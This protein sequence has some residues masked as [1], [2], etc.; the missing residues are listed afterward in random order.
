MKANYLLLTAFSLGLAA[1]FAA[2]GSA[3]ADWIAYNEEKDLG[4][5][6]SNVTD[7]N[8]LGTSSG[9]LTKISDGASTGAT[10]ATS[11]TG[12]AGT[13]SATHQVLFADNGGPPAAGTDAYTTFVGMTDFGSVIELRQKDVGHSPSWPDDS[14]YTHSFSGLNPGMK[15]EFAGTAVRKK[16]T[17]GDTYTNRWTLAR[18]EGADSYVAAHTAIVGGLEEGVVTGGSLPASG[19][20][21]NEVAIWTGENGTATQGFV[22]RWTDI[23]P[24]ADG[25]FSVFCEQYTG[26]IP[27]SV[28]SGG[29][30][31]ATKGY[32][33]NVVRLQEVPE[34][35]TLLLLG[36]G[37]LALAT[38]R[39][40]RGGEQ[41][42][43]IA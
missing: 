43:P 14:S 17:G 6:H 9:L 20:A 4:G 8:V 38:K 7:Y 32:V 19:L 1:Y 27:T 15:Y 2:V 28:D 35:A 12:L 23:D 25:A 21:A 18:L 40:R 42:R 34:P 22:A 26:A 10:L 37:G 5:S 24:G 11:H 36:L 29:M 30:A 41:S 33:L 13:V 39:Q 16:S 31:D 3:G